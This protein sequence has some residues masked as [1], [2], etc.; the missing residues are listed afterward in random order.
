MSPA[1]VCH[2]SSVSTPHDSSLS[3]DD[4]GRFGIIWDDAM[5]EYIKT[6][7]LNKEELDIIKKKNFV[8]E[9]FFPAA[10]KEWEL[11]SLHSSNPW[12]ARLRGILMDLLEKN[13]LID[14]LTDWAKNMVCF[15][16]VCTRIDS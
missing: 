6:A 15:N 11:A 10:K 8:V 16:V 12:K 7:R 3:G 13:N 5:K 2:H 1:L 14:V 9:D 4:Y